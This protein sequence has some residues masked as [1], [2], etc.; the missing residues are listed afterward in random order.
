MGLV[1]GDVGNASSLP[2]MMSLLGLHLK[3]RTQWP[4]Q[5]SRDTS[6]FGVKMGELEVARN[7]SQTYLDEL[8]QVG[9]DLALY[10]E[11]VFLSTK[12]TTSVN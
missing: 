11:V 5:M 2:S 12:P 7:F 6:K 8:I 4:C 3:A 10:G 9:D 1:L